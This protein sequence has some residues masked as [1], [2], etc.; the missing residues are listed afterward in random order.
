[1]PT[2]TMRTFVVESYVV[3]GNNDARG[4]M[5]MLGRFADVRCRLLMTVGRTPN[6]EMREYR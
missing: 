3:D 5:D 2:A 6:T 4:G 1:M